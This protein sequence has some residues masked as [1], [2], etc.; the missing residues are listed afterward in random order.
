M[1]SYQIEAKFSSQN[2]LIRQLSIKG[3]VPTSPLR[4][5]FDFISE[6]LLFR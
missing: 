6:V 4:L 5:I 3:A 2:S 1:Y